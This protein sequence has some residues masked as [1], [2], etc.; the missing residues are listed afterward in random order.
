VDQ[1][2]KDRDACP[3]EPGDPICRRRMRS[4]I[5]GRYLDGGP[6]TWPT[7]T[8][9]VPPTAQRKGSTMAR[10][11]LFVVV[12]AILATNCA[13]QSTSTPTVDTYGDSRAQ[14]TSRDMEECRSLALR[15]SGD[16]ASETGK[17]AVVGGLI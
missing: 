7:P 4:V 12:L 17:G 10:S 11:T 9:H 5:L 1:R 8:L 13:T 14:Y 2:L 6:R 3:S 16:T 15:A